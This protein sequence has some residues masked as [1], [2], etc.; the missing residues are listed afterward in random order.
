[1]ELTDLLNIEEIRH[2]N[3]KMTIDSI[4]EI[5]AKKLFKEYHIKKGKDRYDF[6][7]IEFYYYSKEHPDACTYERNSEAG[8]FYFHLSGID[9]AFKSDSK[10]GCYGGILIRSLLKNSNSENSVVAGPLRC[11]QD[12]FNNTMNINGKTLSI[13]LEQDENISEN[14][15]ENTYRYGIKSDINNGRKYC[16]YMRRTGCDPNW[17]CKKDGKTY[18]YNAK[19]WNRETESN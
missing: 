13:S 8:D 17:T 12:L 4:F 16:Y 3:S 9:I 18:S 10:K 6:L 5:I 11:Q 19:P 14:E 7:E 2:V 1:M 15:P